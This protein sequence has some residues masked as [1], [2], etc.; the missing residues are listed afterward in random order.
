MCGRI[1]TAELTPEDLRRTFRLLT[2]PM[3]HQSYNVAPT[4]PIPAIR[5]QNHI[6]T[7]CAFKWG[8]IPH[9]VKHLDMD[10][11]AFNARG[12]TVAQ[13]P[14]FRD[15]FKSKRCI[16]PVSGFYEWQKREDRKQA[17]YIDRVDHKPIALAGLWDVWEDKEKGERVENCNLITIPATGQMVEIH[18][19]MP[20]ILEPQFFDTWLD[21]EFRETHVLQD[22]LQL[23]AQDALKMYPVSDYVNNAA[24]DGERC[25]Q[26]LEDPDVS[27]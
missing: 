11:S 13:K 3:F 19:R 22:I 8:L 24:H 9:W 1:S 20:A 16:I 27:I 25:L 12:E 15:S 23:P 21:T 2:I 6:R 4:V 7:L 5:E 17:Y 18:A 26:G 10:V 14:F